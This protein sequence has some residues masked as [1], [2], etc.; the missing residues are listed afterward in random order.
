MTKDITLEPYDIELV[1]L[2]AGQVVDWGHAYLQ[3]QKYYGVSRGE[4]AAIFILD[5]AGKFTDHPDLVANCLPEY[6]RNVTNSPAADVHGHGTHCAGISA[7]TDNKVG[8]IGIAPGAKIIA[9]KVLNDSG[10]GSFSWIASQIRDVADTSDNG[11]I[12]GLKRI[13]SLSLG[14]PAGTPTPPTLRQAIDYAIGKGCFVVAAAGNSGYNGTKSTVGAPANY[15]PVIAVASTDKPGDKRSTFSSGG[16]TV[17]IA[18]PGG[19]IYSTHKGGG[20][21]RLSGTSMACP[22]VSGVVALLLSANPEIENQAQ[23]SEYLAKHATDILG[24]GKDNESGYGVPMLT[25]FLEKE[26]DTPSDDPI[27]D[28]PVD[29]TPDA[30]QYDLPRRPDVKTVGYEFTGTMPVY[31]RASNEKGM[32]LGFI[33]RLVVNVTSDIKAQRMAEIVDAYVRHFFKGR[34]VIVKPG[35]D[36]RDVGAWTAVF[37]Q[38]ASNDNWVV[39][40][41]GTEIDLVVKSLVVTNHSGASVLISEEAVR[42]RAQDFKHDELIAADLEPVFL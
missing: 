11:R 38:F 31:Y 17:D 37:L 22:M 32:Q 9:R 30:P 6:D 12:K 8:V 2:A 1:A 25:G 34:A 35:Q 40:M 5:T 24:T 16:E 36:L 7:A 29:D 23:L 33:D 10:S 26:P 41:F 13:I 21:A 42:E 4:G 28:D 14:G 27:D 15:P 19:A 39:E 20:Y 3:A 18:A